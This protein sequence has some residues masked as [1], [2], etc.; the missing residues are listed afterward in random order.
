MSVTRFVVV[1]FGR[2]G[3]SWLCS[4]LQSHPAI[5]CH[6]E[7][8]SPK[9]I[10]Y[11]PGYLERLGTTAPWSVDSRDRHAAGFLEAVL[12][13]D[14]GHQAVG[15]KMLNWMRSEM[16]FDLARR[17]DVHKVILRRRN[18]VRAFLSRTRSEALERWYMESYHGL[19]IRLEPT[20][21][22]EYVERY[23]TFYDEL[24]A[25]TAGTP[26]W[27][28]AYEDLLEDDQRARGIVDFLGVEPR[29][30]RLRSALPRQSRDLTREVVINFEELSSRLR[31]T[32]L[33]AELEA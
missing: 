25:A 16:L 19:R 1:C 8:F 22:I 26:V 27:E 31:G 2:T 30:V 14:L 13:Q 20:E 23:D 7:L 9:G 28:I 10:R 11:A 12:S 29:D 15:F 3:S 24:R 21:L 4:L 5:L 18:R 17:P 33:H 6:E 32:A